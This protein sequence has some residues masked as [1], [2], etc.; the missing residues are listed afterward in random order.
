MKKYYPSD[1]FIRNTYSRKSG[2]DFYNH[3]IKQFGLDK[4][5]PLIQEGIRLSLLNY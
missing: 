4:K 5:Y 1:V 2:F 3:Q